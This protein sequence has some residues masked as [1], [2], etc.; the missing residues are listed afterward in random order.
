MCSRSGSVGGVQ[1]QPDP[2]L[3]GKEVTITVSNGASVVH[4]RTAPDGA[5]HEAPLKDGKA[6]IVV[7]AGSGGKA[8]SIYAGDPPDIVSERFEI[9]E[10]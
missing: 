4:W 7:P 3:A 6:T 10:P 9:L 1:V 8:L 2:P 5:E